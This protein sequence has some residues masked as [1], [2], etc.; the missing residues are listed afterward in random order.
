LPLGGLVPTIKDARGV[1]LDSEFNL[2]NISDISGLVLE[3]WG[4]K[5]KEK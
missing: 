4:P 2:E 1:E 3:S 5:T